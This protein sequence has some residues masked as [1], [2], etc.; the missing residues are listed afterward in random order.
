[1]AEVALQRPV[2][3]TSL[4]STDALAVQPHYD[5]SS[6]TL[7]SDASVAGGNYYLETIELVSRMLIAE[8][9]ILQARG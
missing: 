1:M 4:I 2:V 7:I 9:T 3:L 8:V 6:K 5:P